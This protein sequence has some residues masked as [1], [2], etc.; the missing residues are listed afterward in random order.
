MRRR[1]FLVLAV[2]S[3]L[4][5]FAPPAAAGCIKRH[6]I[7][8]ASGPS[9]SGESWTVEGTIGN[10]GDCR[11]W[12]FGME[13]QLPGA[14]GWGWVTGI[15]SGGHLSKNFMIDASDDLQE[16]GSKRVFSGTAGGDVA[17]I[18]A[19]LSD[20][21][22]LTIQPKSAPAGLRQ[23]VVWLRNAR[24]FVQYYPPDGFVTSVSL[25]SASGQLL[26]RTT[27]AEGSFF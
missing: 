10:N 1:P 13:F 12:L 20:G 17:R 4:I 21:K 23:R 5:I 3:A 22:H 18:V 24:Y 15:P 2:I 14:V 11:E 26:Y 27:S 16:D 8:I 7:P 6:S 9:P 19:T 25:F